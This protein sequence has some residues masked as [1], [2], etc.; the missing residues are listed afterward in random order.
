MMLTLTAD[1][2]N[3]K[4]I[5]TPYKSSAK[6]LGM[7]LSKKREFIAVIHENTPYWAM[8]KCP[9]GCGTV[10]FAFVTENP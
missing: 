6:P 1:C 3:P 2:Q 8:F 10:Y 9:C 4:Y 7:Q 5:L